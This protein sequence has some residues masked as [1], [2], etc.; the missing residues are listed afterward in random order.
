MEETFWRSTLKSDQTVLGFILKTH[1]DKLGTASLGN[2]THCKTVIKKEK[3][4]RKYKKFLI[5]IKFELLRV[6]VYSLSSSYHT[7]M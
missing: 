7:A 4:G 3:K 5:Y 6:Y 2:L 1:K